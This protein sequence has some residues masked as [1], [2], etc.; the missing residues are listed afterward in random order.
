[1]TARMKI[2]S[3]AL[4]PETVGV[5]AGTNYPE[6]FKAGVE[7]REKRALGDAIGLN[8]FGVNQ[9][10]LKPGV[11]SS[12]RHWHTHE[13][14]F[15]MVLEGELTLITDA[16]E[17]ALGPGMAAGFPA[18]SG[19]GHHLINRGDKDAVYL[20]VGGRDAQDDVDYP[21]ID[22]MR[23]TRDGARVF[24]HKDETPY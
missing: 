23:R 2:I 14:E 21:D 17:Q 8:D 12:Q 7:G 16:G 6:P 24:L 5:R 10:R 15:V 20:E 19:D 9:V 13:D 4:D 3:P 1:M 11:M 18:G 22:M